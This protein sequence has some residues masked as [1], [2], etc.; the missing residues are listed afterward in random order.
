MRSLIPIGVKDCSEVCRREKAYQVGPRGTLL[1]VVFITAPATVCLLCGLRS[2][3]SQTS[4]NP[5]ESEIYL[6]FP[7]YKKESTVRTDFQADALTQ[8]HVLVTSR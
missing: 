6:S 7:L 4:L 8:Q 2:A 3:V 5:C 1:T